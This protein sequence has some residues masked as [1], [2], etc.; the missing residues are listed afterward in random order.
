MTAGVSALYGAVVRVRRPDGSIVGGGFLVAPGLVSTCAHV[1]AQALGT[2][3]RSADPPQGRVGLDFPL[4]GS[5]GPD[6]PAGVSRGTVSARVVGWRPLRADDTGDLAL[7]RLDE[8]PP[9]ATVPWMV[10]ANELWD[11]AVRVLGFP[12][13]SDHGVWVAGRLRALQGAGWI[14]MQSEAGPAIEGGFSG[15]PVWDTGLAGVVGMAVAAGTGSG[16]NT[17]YLLPSSVILRTWP[18]LAERVLPSSP[19]RGLSSFTEQDEQVFFGRDE[20]AARLETL[21]ARQPVVVLAGPSGSG[22]SSLVRAGL[23]PRLNRGNWATADFRPIAGLSPAQTLAGALAPLLEGELDER[24]LTGRL[25]SAGHAEVAARL[26][27][28]YPRGVLLFADQFEEMVTADQEAAREI[29][30]LLWALTRETSSPVPVRGLTTVRSGSLDRMLTEQNQGTL[31]EGV[32][33]L[34]PMGREQ[35]RSAITGPLAVTPGV[36]LEPGLVE[37]ILDDAG[38]GPGRLPLVEF[39]LTRLWD[40][41]H[42]G[43]LTHEAY[44]GFGGVPGS[45]ADY[46]EEVYDRQL[47]PSERESAR[48][49]FVQLA[50]PEE[51]GGFTRRAV[52]V[53]DLDED[54]RRLV[55]RLADRKLLVTSRAVDGAEIADLA[56]DALIGSWGRLRD[57]LAAD[58]EFRSWQER[59]RRNLRQWERIGRLNGGLLQEPMLTEALTWS[60]RRPQDITAEERAYIDAGRALRNRRA[61][62]GRLVTG[63]IAVLAVL[64]ATLAG[65]TYDRNQTVTRQLHAQ[66]A[67]LLG[68]DAQRRAD[69]AQGTAALLALSAWHTDKTQPEAYGALFKLYTRL[70]NTERVRELSIDHA[71]SFTAA[72]DGSAAVVVDQR[73]VVHRLTGLL[74]KVEDQV[75][76]RTRALNEHT[77]LV[78]ISPDGRR[79][80]LLDEREGL[81]VWSPDRP[82]SPVR[83]PVPAGWDAAHTVRDLAFSPDGSRLAALFAGPHEGK[84]ERDRLGLWTADGGRPVSRRT[85]GPGSFYRVG[86]GARPD[87]VLLY[88]EGDDGGYLQVDLRTGGDAGSFPIEFPADLGLEGQVVVD[89][90][91]GGL[92]IRSTRDGA[93]LHTV[94]TTDCASQLLDGTRRYAV[95]EPGQALGSS[96]LTTIKLVDLRSGLVSW[97]TAPAHEALEGADFAVCPRGDGSLSVLALKGGEL[98]RFTAPR[99]SRLVRHPLPHQA[100]ELLLSDDGRFRLLADEEKGTVR[101]LDT[102]DGVISTPAAGVQQ[103]LLTAWTAG[104]TVFTSDG[105]HLVAADG[106]SMTVY[107]TPRLTPERTITLPSAPGT[108]GSIPTSL[109]A[110]DDGSV[111]ALRAGALSRWNPATGRPFGSPLPLA[112]GADL[113]WLAAHG[114][115]VLPRPRHPAQ[116]LVRGRDGVTRLWDLGARRS[117]GA[118]QADPD[119][120]GAWPGQAFDAT[121]DT[122]AV[123]SNMKAEHAATI[124]FLRLPD[125]HLLAPPLQAGDTYGLVG[126][127]PDGYLISQGPDH[128]GV[129]RWNTPK[130]I[131]DLAVPDYLWFVHGATVRGV[132]DT[133]SV[134]LPL[135]PD[136]W[137]ARLCR[138]VHRPL[139]GAER[140]L[141]PHGTAPG[142]PCG[143]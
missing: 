100:S 35:L 38:E 6:A 45:V 37:R 39:T 73:G 41:H 124:E 2:D 10:E 135:D 116:A 55:P 95:V 121:G 140:R 80:A 14:Q 92:R 19:Y 65:V 15:C 54:Q 97:A 123:M 107:A 42:G 115:R 9:A 87:S 46:A 89:C 74:G 141:L 61:R 102:S 26:R 109:A 113:A 32:M 137:R 4:L 18:E 67:V 17:A 127:G 120:I 66:A 52:R 70:R 3:A 36:T 94:A 12:P 5:A 101:L 105:R 88:H 131:A 62:R 71:L 98:L 133:G 90:A 79:V 25:A 49:L 40:R 142:E 76:T 59:L 58:R 82:D 53:D 96:D 47:R 128:L 33:L 1:V 136:R 43:V 44:D 111:L 85:L 29:L 16:R 129:W 60:E 21:V 27:R 110:A 50:R 122:L 93:P 64:A 30:G 63:V 112:H 139:T 143:D 99:P 22:K 56:H 84:S 68:Q 57:W 103:R 104:Q 91:P 48:R 75:F 134:T 8:P 31:G 130:E 11:H 23:L 138:A 83:L 117:R 126:F 69:S 132:T 78:K 24:E 119:T 77:P 108:H 106:A 7:L 125:F 20:A 34:A 81:T 72:P 86:F 51:D 118:F 13:G 114:A 28:R